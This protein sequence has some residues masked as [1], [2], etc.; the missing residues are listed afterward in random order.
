MTVRFETEQYE[1]SHGKRPRGYGLW[2]IEVDGKEI[3]E[4]YGTLTEIKKNILKMCEEKGIK[5]PFR[6]KVLA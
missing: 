3:I 4:A 5:N 6:F 1:F 2:M